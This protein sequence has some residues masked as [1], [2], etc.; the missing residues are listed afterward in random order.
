M[1]AI[2]ANSL[3]RRRYFRVESDLCGSL[4][5]EA[6]QHLCGQRQRSLEVGGKVCLEAWCE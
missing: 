6:Q 4:R 1:L 2:R 3:A 5:V